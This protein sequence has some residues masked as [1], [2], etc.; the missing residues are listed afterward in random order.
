MPFKIPDYKSVKD[1]INSKDSRYFKVYDQL[2]NLISHED[3]NLEFRC[4]KD[5]GLGLC[6]EFPEFAW[7]LVD[8]NESNKI[9][10]VPNSNWNK[11]R[12]DLSVS[13]N[14]LISSNWY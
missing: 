13:L 11:K 7:L 9:D 10:F 4:V 8:N 6:I 1:F 12:W 2:R 14:S 3:F 5:D